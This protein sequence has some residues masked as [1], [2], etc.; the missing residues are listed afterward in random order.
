MDE[1]A[2]LL[3][4]IDY[5]DSA[6]DAAKD[7]DCLLVLTEWTQF[8]ALD[9]KRLKQLLRRPVVVDL[10]NVFNPA[11]MRGMGFTY[12]CI[13]RPQPHHSA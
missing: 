4:G 10:R 6:Y 11:E 7:A 3:K 13:G 12:E 5:K 1:A 2:R 8:R 9:P